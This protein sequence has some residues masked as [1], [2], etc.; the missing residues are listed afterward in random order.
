MAET[1]EIP[2]TGEP[3]KNQ[4]WEKFCTLVA[5][6]QSVDDA[7]ELA[8]FAPHHANA[9]RLRAR[10]EI[11]MRI[12]HLSSLRAARVVDPPPQVVTPVPELTPEEIERIEATKDYV[13]SS[14]IHNAEVALGRRL[15]KSTIR[16]PRKKP[17]KG[18]VQAPADAAPTI[19][20]EHTD[21]NGSVANASL[22]ALG[23]HIGMWNEKTPA[24]DPTKAGAVKLGDKERAARFLAKY[25]KPAPPP[26]GADG[27]NSPTTS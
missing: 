14:L 7:Y 22:I 2:D 19:T 16:V 17:G 5:N 4:K 13:V 8:G 11:E 15:T 24:E 26:A 27:T 3:L 20:F 21:R 18:V 10:P 1:P 12:S 6:G 25:Y 9:Y 23:K